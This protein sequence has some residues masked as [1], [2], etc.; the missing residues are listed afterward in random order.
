MPDTIRDSISV[1]CIRANTPSEFVNHD[2]SAVNPGA[3]QQHIR[4]DSNL[5]AQLFQ[6]TG[7]VRGERDYSKGDTGPLVYPAGVLYVYSAIQYV[8]GGE[9]YPAQCCRFNKDECDTTCF[10]SITSRAKSTGMDI[11]GVISA[12]AGAALVQ[13]LALSSTFLG[14]SA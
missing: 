10:I 7:F 12:L 8:T 9:V 11:I 5:M 13:V 4:S 6:V 2:G 1:K 14:L 3:F